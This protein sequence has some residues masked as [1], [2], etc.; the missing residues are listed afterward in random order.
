VIAP[1]R[2]KLLSARRFRE[3]MLA[4]PPVDPHFAKDLGVTRASV[5]PPA[6]PWEAA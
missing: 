5:G 1:P 4:A 6:D 3:L 2:A